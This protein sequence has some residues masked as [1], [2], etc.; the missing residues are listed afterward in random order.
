S[1]AVGVSAALTR[2]LNQLRQRQSITQAQVEALRADRVDGLRGIADQH[3][4]RRDGPV[5]QYPGCRIRGACAA[6][7]EA[8]DTPTKR[9]LGVLQET[10]LVEAGDGIGCLPRNRVY[11]SVVAVAARQQRRRAVFPE[12]LVGGSVRAALGA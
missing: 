10:G 1:A 5:R 4:A 12:P 2:A 6:S 9:G 7:K 3:R 11:Q 8:S